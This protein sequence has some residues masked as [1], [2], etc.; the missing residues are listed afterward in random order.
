MGDH[1]GHVNIWTGRCKIIDVEYLKEKTSATQ[2]RQEA[3]GD[4][5]RREII[6]YK[7]RDGDV[8][9]PANDLETQP[10][11]TFAKEHFLRQRRNEK[12]LNKKAKKAERA[13][14]QVEKKH[15]EG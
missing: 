10:G 9:F 4:C 2:A 12:R 1:M 15:V 13:R 11:K 6:V 8:D 3:V 5:D 7:W 14:I